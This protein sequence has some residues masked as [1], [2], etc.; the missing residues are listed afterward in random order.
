MNS[1][2]ARVGCNNRPFVSAFS[3]AEPLFWRSNPPPLFF[4]LPC[5]K[6]GR[7]VGPGAAGVA[8][9]WYFYPS[10]RGSGRIAHAVD[11]MVL[12]RLLTEAAV[13]IVGSSLF[14]CELCRLVDVVIVIDIVVLICSSQSVGNGVD[15]PSSHRSPLRDPA[16]SYVSLGGGSGPILPH[17]ETGLSGVG[18]HGW[19]LGTPGRC[20]WL[21]KVW[22][23][24]PLVCLDEIAV[25]VRRSRRAVV[26]GGRWW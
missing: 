21:S 8:L 23:G 19:G 3:T 18:S 5:G 13:R 4:S 9:S 6:A 1:D 7:L 22:V 15:T 11:G 10:A 26:R 25:V 20:V 16:L 17:H 2:G 14:R 24:V 12:C